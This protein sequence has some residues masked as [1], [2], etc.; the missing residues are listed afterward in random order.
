MPCTTVD[1]DCAIRAVLC[2]VCSAG[3]TGSFTHGLNVADAAQ[4][5]CVANNSRAGDALLQVVAASTAALKVA[6]FFLSPVFAPMPFPR[7]RAHRPAAFSE[8]FMP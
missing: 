1:W 4:W 7:E 3:A 2:A 5:R 8:D 6:R